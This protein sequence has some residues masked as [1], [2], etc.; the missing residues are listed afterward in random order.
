MHILVVARLRGNGYC[1]SRFG[2]TLARLCPDSGICPSLAMVYY[3]K[4]K[5]LADNNKG[6][7]T[8]LL[9]QIPSNS[10]MKIVSQQYQ[11]ILKYCSR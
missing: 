2:L 4:D 10:H 9:K 6:T 7:G 1:L 8:S 3:E 5:T 11:N